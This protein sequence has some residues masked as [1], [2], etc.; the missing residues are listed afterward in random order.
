M[1]IPVSELCADEWTVEGAEDPLGPEE[2]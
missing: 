2:I 1:P